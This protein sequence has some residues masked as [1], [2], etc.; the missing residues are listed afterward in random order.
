MMRKEWSSRK[1]EV[2]K[3]E[4]LLTSLGGG[5]EQPQLLVILA[6]LGS[7]TDCHWCAPKFCVGLQ[8]G[9]GVVLPLFSVLSPLLARTAD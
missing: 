6:A 2:L 5:V 1:Q 8:S 4:G 3:P 7:R 9:L